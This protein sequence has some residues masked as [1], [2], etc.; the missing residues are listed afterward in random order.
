MTFGKIKAHLSSESHCSSS[1]VPKL[2]L[3]VLSDAKNPY[4]GLLGKGNAESYFY[5]MLTSVEV[6]L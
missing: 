4:R 2:V 3:T 5:G 1:G 6:E